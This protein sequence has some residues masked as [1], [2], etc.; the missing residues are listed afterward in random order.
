M[1]QHEWEDELLAQMEDHPH[2][3]RIVLDDQ[4]AFGEERDLMISKVSFQ[5]DEVLLVVESG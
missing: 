5:D 3:L 4:D 1:E 2:K